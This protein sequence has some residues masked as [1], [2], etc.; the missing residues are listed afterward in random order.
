MWRELICGCKQR[1]LWGDVSTRDLYQPRGEEEVGE[2]VGATWFEEPLMKLQGM[3]RIG[4]LSGMLGGGREREE[5]WQD[6]ASSS[7]P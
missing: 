3:W 5:L 2:A 4:L 7:L 1:R 6:P